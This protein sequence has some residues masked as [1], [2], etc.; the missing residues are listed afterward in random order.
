MFGSSGQC[1]YTSFRAC[2]GIQS[3]S[4]PPHAGV[5]RGTSIDD[6]NTSYSPSP[7]ARWTPDSNS[8]DTA[9]FPVVQSVDLPVVHAHC[10]PCTPACAGAKRCCLAV[11]AL[12]GIPDA[13]P[14]QCPHLMRVSCERRGRGMVSGVKGVTEETLPW[15]NSYGSLSNQVD[16]APKPENN[17]KGFT[18]G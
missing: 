14:A 8:I 10:V 15:V 4:P 17:Q 12:S 9:V 6:S 5:E 16:A 13:P 3:L 7:Q 11:K 18:L 2:P 1:L